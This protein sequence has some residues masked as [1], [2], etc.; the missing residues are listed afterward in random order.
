MSDADNRSPS[1]SFPSS[2]SSHQPHYQHHSTSSAVESPTDSTFP[3]IS[4]S[5]KQYDH[6]SNSTRRDSNHSHF[7]QE[8]DNT[9]PYPE[10]HSNDNSDRS[11]RSS[12]FDRLNHLT[13]PISYTTSAVLRRLSEDSAPTPL[14]RALS[15]NYNGLMRENAPVFNP[16]TRRHSPFQPPPLTPLTLQGYKDSTGYKGRLLSKALAEEIR[17]LVPPRLQLVDTWKLGYSLEQDGSSLRSLFGAVDSYRGKRGGFVLMIRDGRHGVSW[18]FVNYEA[19]K[20]RYAAG[21]TYETTR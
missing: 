5:P 8:P 9:L 14:A 15:A 6:S 20:S 1:P 19:R 2:S 13:F 10:D 21:H 16:P 4:K 3:P 18:P 12:F 11:L 7:H 17:L